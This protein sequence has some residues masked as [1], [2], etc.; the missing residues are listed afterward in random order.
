MEGFREPMIMILLV[1]LVVEIV[2]FFMGE[3]DWYEPVG[4]VIAIILSNGVSSISENKQ[5][6]KA[7]ALKEAELAKEKTKVLRDGNMKEIHVS[8]V[9][10]GDIVYLQAGDKIPADGIIL[11]GSIKVDQAAL[12]GETEEA[13]KE[14][15]KTESHLIQKI[16]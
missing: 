12:N 5:Q 11:D 3:A 16:C 8:D 9:V 2:M 10:T 1:A 6:K 4:I 14:P 13:T 7:A 15:R